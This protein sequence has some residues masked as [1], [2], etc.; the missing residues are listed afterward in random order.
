[1]KIEIDSAEVVSRSFEKDGR[2]FTFREQHAWLHREDEKYPT[3]FRLSLGDFPAYAVGFYA[4]APGSFSV[5]KY[6]N[7]ALNRQLV[8]KKI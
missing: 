6:G 2:S 5:N 4:L 8:L 7:L 3:S 1:M